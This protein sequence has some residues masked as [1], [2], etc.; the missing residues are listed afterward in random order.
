MNKIKKWR[1]S[2]FVIVFTLIGF[3]LFAQ[4]NSGE[5]SICGGGGLSFFCYQKPVSSASSFG[6]HGDIGVGFTGFVSQQCG[7]HIGAGLGLFKIKTKV[8]DL[9]TFTPN[10]TDWNDHLYNLYTTLSGYSEIH[11]MMSLNVPFMF[12][13]QT[14]MSQ[15]WNWKK[16]Q[17]ACY[18]AMIGAKLHLLFKRSYDSQITTLYNAAHYPV[19]DNWATT[20]TFA[21][22]GDFVGKDADGK[23][24]VGILAMFAFE[25]GVKWQIGEKLFLYTGVYFDCGLNDPT[26]NL[27]KPVSNYISVADLAGLSLL[28]FYD[29][30][31]LMGTG[32]KLRLAFYKPQKYVPCR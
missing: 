22:L 31:I 21:G 11:K 23:L 6:Y 7:F 12:Q 3:Q 18:Y 20:Q 16:T 30:S 5:F 10:L 27:R 13:F 2:L 24:G 25:T 19:A 32:I 4:K 15:G 29:K 8:G 28:S 9:K 17:K 1:H 14:K 26:K